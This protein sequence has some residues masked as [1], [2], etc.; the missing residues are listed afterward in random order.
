MRDY[1]QSDL[2][3]HDRA[4]FRSFMK[5]LTSLNSVDVV[6]F[7]EQDIVRSGFVKEYIIA[8]NKIGLDV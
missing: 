4:G 8:R 5:V 6:T 7:D 1:I 2:K 3:R